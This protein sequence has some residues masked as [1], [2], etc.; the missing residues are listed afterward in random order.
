MTKAVMF[1][2][3]MST[4][5]VSAASAQNLSPYYNASISGTYV[6]IQ[7]GTQSFGQSTPNTYNSPGSFIQTRTNWQTDAAA[8]P[9]HGG[10]V[11]AD[12][13]AAPP[14][15]TTAAGGYVTDILSQ[16]SATYY[17]TVGGPVGHSIGVFVGASGTISWSQG[18]MAGAAF[19]VKDYSNYNGH[20]LID[21]EINWNDPGNNLLKGNSH[22]LDNRELILKGGDIYSVVISAD[23]IYHANSYLG[24]PDGT[25]PYSEDHAVVDPTFTIDSAYK[26]ANLFTLN[27][28]GG[29][30]I[31]AVAAVPE[32]STWAMMILGFVGIGFMTYRQKSKPALMAA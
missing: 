26:D 21:D 4:M 16:A 3:L 1:A 13:L 15:R 14:P 18:G 19:I 11:Q 20:P 29:P 5:V 28:D 27:A 17:F 24:A 9:D 6:D 12:I 22:F 25:F 2:A 10:T 7:L 8:A 31:S 23:T 30:L 32:S